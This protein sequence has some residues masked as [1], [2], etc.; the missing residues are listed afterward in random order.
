METN[1]FKALLLSYFTIC[2]LHAFTSLIW[3]QSFDKTGNRKTVPSYVMENAH[4]LC[5]N[6][7]FAWFTG[8]TAGTESSFQKYC[9]DSSTFRWAS[10]S[11]FVS[12]W[13]SFLLGLWRWW[14]TRS[15]GYSVCIK[16]NH[17]IYLQVI[18]FHSKDYFVMYISNVQHLTLGSVTEQ[19]LHSP[20]IFSLSRI[21]PVHC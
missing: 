16:N 5:R 15:W 13:W 17:N 18:W 8:T 14:K 7:A 6:I 3:E 19:N 10:L 2:F 9:E 4:R 21:F 12:K 1:N 20:C 11:G